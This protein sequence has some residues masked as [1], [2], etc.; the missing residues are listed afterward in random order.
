MNINKDTSFPN[1][2]SAFTLI[3]ILLVMG[4]LGLLAGLVIAN[5]DAIF[6]GNQEKV[7][8]MFVNQSIETPLTAYK[9]STSSY[10]TTEEGLR[11]LLV[12]PDKVK[13]NWKG[14]YIKKEP[15]DPWQQPYQ[16]R[17]PGQHNPQSYDVWSKGPDQVS[18]SS[19]DI[20]NW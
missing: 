12:A 8:S 14:P 13:K 3:E 20:G 5:A 17:S 15:I 10:P 7:A 6:G 18:G 19:D 9:F 2:K 1:K 16:Y 11:A 4:I